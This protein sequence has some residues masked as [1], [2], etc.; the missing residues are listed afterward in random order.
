MQA[1]ETLAHSFGMAVLVEVHNSEELDYALQLATPLIG[2]NNRN[3]R[4]FEVTCRPRWTCCRASL[5]TAFGLVEDRFPNVRARR[6]PR[7]SRRRGGSSTWP[8]RARRTSWRSSTPR[9]F[10][11]VRLVVVTEPSRFLRELPDGLTERW[12][13]ESGPPALDRLALPARSPL[14]RPDAG[15]GPT[16]TSR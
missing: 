4:T 8:R 9:I 1:Y 3:L 16:R 10:R 2:V 6:P 11:P 13:L 12:V 15:S 5:A 14:G 7:G